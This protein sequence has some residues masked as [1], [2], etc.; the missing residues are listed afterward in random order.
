MRESTFDLARKLISIGCILG[1]AS[2]ADMGSSTFAPGAH[3]QWTVSEASTVHM[4]QVPRAADIQQ[5]LA[6]VRS[7]RAILDARELHREAAFSDYLTAIDTA[8]RAYD[9]ETVGRREMSLTTAL[10]IAR[11]AL[12]EGVTRL[13]SWT[14]IVRA[15]GLADRF[16]SVPDRFIESP[17]PLAHDDTFTNATTETWLDLDSLE[18]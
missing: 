18:V 15:S 13:S 5:A 10:A 8:L 1:A 4:P 14:S 2:L 9:V 16:T 7:A 6:E 12:L 17:A 3:A 11:T